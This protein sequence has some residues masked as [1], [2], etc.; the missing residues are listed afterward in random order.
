MRAA[1]ILAAVT[2]S[3]AGSAGCGAC[4]PDRPEDTVAS[5]SAAPSA[6]PRPAGSVPGIGSAFTPRPPR[7]ACR[8]IEVA[9]DV[10]MEGW[11]DGGTF[12][13]LLQGLVPEQGW[14]AL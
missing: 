10:H 6:P 5:A 4:E 11:G 13:L 3:I 2:A 14:L 8:A 7:L 1:G 9:G 12:P